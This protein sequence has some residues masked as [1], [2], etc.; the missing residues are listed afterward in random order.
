MKVGYVVNVITI[1]MQAFCLM[2]VLFVESKQCLHNYRYYYDS[3]WN[4]NNL[5][6]LGMNLLQ[7]TLRIMTHDKPIVQDLDDLGVEEINRTFLVVNMIV[8]VTSSIKIMEL[9]RMYEQLGNLIAL[10][11]TAIFDISGFLMF[12]AIFIVT[13]SAFY[14]MVGAT[15]DD[16]E[17]TGV[18]E[19]MIYF[20]QTLNNSIG[21]ISTPN[22]KYWLKE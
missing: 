19:F 11:V 3:F 14:R 22:Y 17:Y 7:L 12:F 9:L 10:L 21:D 4:K 2:V 13:I 5:V 18:Y 20:M 1:V 8:L 15:F 6:Y 16:Q